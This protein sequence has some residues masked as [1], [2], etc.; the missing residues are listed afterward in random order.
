MKNNIFI[1]I[2]LISVNLTGAE[3]KTDTISIYSEILSENRTILLFTPQDIKKSDS[4]S[5]IYLTDG[6]FSRYRFKQIDTISTKKIVG[7][8]I[9][10][11]DRRRDLLPVNQANKFCDFIEKELYLTIEKKF[12]VKERILFGH[13]FAGAFTIYSMINRPAQFNKYIASSPTPIMNLI[14][15]EF[16]KQLNDKLPY[17][18]KLYVSYGSNDMKQVIKWGAKLIDNLTNIRI[19]KIQWTSEVFEGQNHNT[20]ARFSIVNGLNF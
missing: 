4:V 20:S 12:I 7:V 15:P 14:D 2:L 6:E 13:S 8:G 16:Y 3:F 18:I 10:N 9:I 11:T 17:E 5:I 1:F 19:D